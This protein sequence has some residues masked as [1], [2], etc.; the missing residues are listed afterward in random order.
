MRYLVVLLIL[1]G[2]ASVEEAAQEAAVSVGG[3]VGTSL[4][5]SAGEAKKAKR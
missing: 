5:G 4:G 1:A 3:A 2:C